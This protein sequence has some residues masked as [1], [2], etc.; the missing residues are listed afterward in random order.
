LDSALGGTIISTEKLFFYLCS[1]LLVDRVFLLGKVLGVFGSS[2]EVVE[3]ITSANFSSL[4]SV[5]GGSAGTDVTGGMET[6]VDDML[7]VVERF[8][9]MTIRIFS[10]LTE[11]LLHDA[12]L[13][14]AHPG[15]LI[16]R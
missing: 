2:G 8:P 14:K 3:N 9:Q 16:S 6:K 13:G 10:G 12:L 1:V 4:F 11:N 5:L 15:T 7:S